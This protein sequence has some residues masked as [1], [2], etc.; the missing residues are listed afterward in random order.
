MARD[1]LSELVLALGSEARTRSERSSFKVE[2]EQVQMQ[3]R[4]AG[5]EAHVAGAQVEKGGWPNMSVEAPGH[6]KPSRS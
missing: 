3:R 5:G 1:S 4:R 6:L 2:R